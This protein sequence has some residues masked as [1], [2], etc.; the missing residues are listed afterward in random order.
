MSEITS[1]P[2]STAQPS[3]LLHAQ[4][5]DGRQSGIPRGGHCLPATTSPELTPTAQGHPVP[6][7]GGIATSNSTSWP[8]LHH[9]APNSSEPAS[10]PAASWAGLAAHPYARGARGAGKAAERLPGTADPS[11]GEGEMLLDAAETCSDRR[12][13]AATTAELSPPGIPSAAQH[14][15]RQL[16]RERRGVRLQWGHCHPPSSAAR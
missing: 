14:Q 12:E 7:G 15:P 4:H 3:A 16:P 13:P 2:G 1:G 9:F 6:W 11:L 5:A 10:P 8:F